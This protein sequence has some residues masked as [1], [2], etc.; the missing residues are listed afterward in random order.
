MRHRHLKIGNKSICEAKPTKVTA[1]GLYNPTSKPMTKMLHQTNQLTSP[2]NATGTLNP[3]IL[4][5]KVM[6]TFSEVFTPNNGK[7]NVAK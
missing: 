6:K 3:F 5:P 4:S 2:N 7:L 1:S